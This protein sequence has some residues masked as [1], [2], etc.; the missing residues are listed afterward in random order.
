MVPLYM[1]LNAEL[2]LP[3]HQSTAHD[4]S[5]SPGTHPSTWLTP[6]TFTLPRRR[7]HFSLQGAA[8]ILMSTTW[9]HLRQVPNLVP[10]MGSVLHISAH[11][12]YR[13]TTGDGD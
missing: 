13:S 12:Q 5:A 8:V 2:P 1:P 4:P 3:A 9:L 11:H 7:L 10:M 6:R